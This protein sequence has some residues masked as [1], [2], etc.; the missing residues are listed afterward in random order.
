MPK[1][2]MDIVDYRAIS[3][4]PKINLKNMKTANIEVTSGDP[5]VCTNPKIAEKIFFE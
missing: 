2:Q 5:N 4:S 1:K 3:R